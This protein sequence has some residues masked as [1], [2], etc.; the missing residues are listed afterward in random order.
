MRGP[1]FVTKSNFDTMCANLPQV[2]S[3]REIFLNFDN[4]C[5]KC[6][7]APE[8]LV[9]QWVFSILLDPKKFFRIQIQHF[10]RIRILRPRKFKTYSTLIAFILYCNVVCVMEP[11][12]QK[13][14]LQ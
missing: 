2:G 11:V 13:K 9:Y 6:G 1:G 4:L 10:F 7:L 14:I 12:R 3:L 5:V 8:K